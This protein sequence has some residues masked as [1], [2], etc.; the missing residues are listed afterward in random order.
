[1]AKLSQRDL[2]MLKLAC[3]MELP[4]VADKLNMTLDAVH[5]R[6]YWIRQKR[7]AAQ[8]F[9]NHCNNADKMCPKLK[10]LLTSGDLKEK[11]KR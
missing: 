5:S 4:I 8:T 11:R 10:K 2:Q 7:K 9:V 6:F 1:M 3:Q